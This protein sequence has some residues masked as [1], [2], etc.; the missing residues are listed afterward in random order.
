MAAHFVM[1]TISKF[2]LGPVIC[3]EFGKI[4]FRNHLDSQENIFPGFNQ[5]LVSGQIMPTFCLKS[6]AKN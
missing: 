4:F 5:K 6:K 3:E 1:Q 2:F